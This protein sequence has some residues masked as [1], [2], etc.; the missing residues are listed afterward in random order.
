VGFARKGPRNE[1]GVVTV[2]NNIIQPILNQMCD[3]PGAQGQVGTSLRQYDAIDGANHY[4]APYGWWTEATVQST[5]YR[6]IQR[7]GVAGY[8]VLSEQPYSSPIPQRSDI[9]VVDVGGDEELGI[10]VKSTWNIADTQADID[11]LAALLENGDIDYGVA[12]FTATS[13]NFINWRTQLIQY[14][15]NTTG[16]AVEVGGVYH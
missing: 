9:M 4:Y 1:S 7:L 6:F 5:F 15:N 2:Q 16:G 13:D 12:I 3:R 11:K 14:S 10:E 8:L